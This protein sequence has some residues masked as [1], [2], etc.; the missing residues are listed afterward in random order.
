MGKTNF[1]PL[2]GPEQELP[3]YVN[4]IGIGHA[5]E[6]VTYHNPAKRIQLH[7]TIIGCGIAEIDGKRHMLTHGSLLYTPPEKRLII[8]PTPSGWIDNWISLNIPSIGHKNLNALSLGTEPRIL[9]PENPGEFAKLYES[10]ARS[11]TANT[12]DGRLDA[13]ADAYKLLILA[14]KTANS[15]NSPHVTTAESRIVFRATSFIDSHLAEPLPLDRLC[16]TC[17]KVSRQ[18]LCRVFK[19]QTG[20]TLGDYILSR[21]LAKAKDLLAHTELSVSEIAIQSGF[22]SDSYFYRCWKRT[23]TDS[24]TEYRRTHTGVFV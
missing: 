13:A 1:Y 2:Q 15:E 21:R 14:I 9:R 3:V 23:E 10:V 11:L 17:G 5:Q 19:N 18:Y 4:G 16:E 22:G 8:T 6:I 12:L 7:L 20:M 24:P